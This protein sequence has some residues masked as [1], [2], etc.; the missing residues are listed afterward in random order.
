MDMNRLIDVAVL[1]LLITAKLDQEVRVGVQAAVFQNLADRQRRLSRRLRFLI[2][3]IG[4]GVNSVLRLLRL[5]RAHADLLIAS[6]GPP[7]APSH[8][9][10]LRGLP[11]GF[12]TS[13]GRF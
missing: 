1:D 5:G 3:K 6:C 2:Q 11:S 10:R 12:Y 9:G 7:R 4:D 8:S 13:D